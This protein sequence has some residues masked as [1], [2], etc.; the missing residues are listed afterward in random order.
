[1]FLY[2]VGSKNDF[3]PLGMTQTLWEIYRMGLKLT[4]LKYHN[5]KLCFSYLVKN[6]HIFDRDYRWSHLVSDVKQRVGE[7][8]KV[9][10][11][12]GVHEGLR[13]KAVLK[14]VKSQLGN[15]WCIRKVRRHPLKISNSKLTNYTNQKLI[16]KTN[17]Q[18]VTKLKF[19]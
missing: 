5:F 9:V 13:I 15:K 3:D 8:P 7:V 1:M 19:M 14:Q 12:C 17:S 11:D 6:A 2:R 4:I 16:T 10:V 18:N